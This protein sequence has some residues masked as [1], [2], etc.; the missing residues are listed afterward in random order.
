MVNLVEKILDV[1]E[2]QLDK[3]HIPK[4]SP[5]DNKFGPEIKRRF[6]DE[7]IPNMPELESEE[8]TEKRR[9]TK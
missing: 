8:S 2:R 5:I 3:F 7:E 9:K 1:N 4:K 6:G